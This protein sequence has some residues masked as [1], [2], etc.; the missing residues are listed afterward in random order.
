MPNPEGPKFRDCPHLAHVEPALWDEVNARLEEANKGFGRK[1]VNGVDPRWRVARKRTRFPGQHARCHY[2][3][4]QFV[5]GGNGMAHNLMCNGS[6]S[7][8]CWNS[9]GFDGGLAAGRV[10]AAIA[11][12]LGRLDGFDGQLRDLVGQARAWA[13]PATV[14]RRAARLEK[15]E[16]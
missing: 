12:E 11:D 4:R 16:R 6:R 15:E 10:V 7:R 8:Q 9:V 3:G 14:G 5:W 1:P 2:C 13:P